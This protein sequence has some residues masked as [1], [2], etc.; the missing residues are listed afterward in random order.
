MYNREEMAKEAGV[1]LMT[2]EE[3]EAAGYDYSYWPEYLDWA[4]NEELFISDD[5]IMYLIDHHLDTDFLEGLNSEIA[6]VFGDGSIKESIECLLDPDSAPTTI[7]GEALS[8]VERLDLM[9]Q[10]NG[11]LFDKSDA[12]WM[13]SK[14]ITVED[15]CTHPYADGGYE[16]PRVVSWAMSYGL[17]KEEE[18][19]QE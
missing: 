19:E 7:A 14:G 13:I 10:I 17:L 5:D 9:F 2:K 11:D 8:D 3:I 15:Y 12:E 1:K 16:H 4:E 18:E 6:Y